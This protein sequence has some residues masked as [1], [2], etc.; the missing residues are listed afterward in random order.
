[1]SEQPTVAD[2]TAAAVTAAYPGLRQAHP[3]S[4][5]QPLADV[6]VEANG[7]ARF[8]T[9]SAAVCPSPPSA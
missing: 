2:E 8:A 4:L 3:F 9:P 1:M 6:Y 5:G 7:G